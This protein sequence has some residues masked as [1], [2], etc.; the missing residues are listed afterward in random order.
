M[1]DAYLDDLLDEL[2]P[3]GLGKPGMT[4]STASAA[5]GGGTSRQL[6]RS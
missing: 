1:M 4:S 6:R 3:A 5:R 2:V